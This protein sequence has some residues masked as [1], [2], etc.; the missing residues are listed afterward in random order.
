[1]KITMEMSKGAYEIAKKVYSE[2]L[3]R[4]EGKSEK[5]T[6][7]RPPFHSNHFLEVPL[8]TI[9]FLPAAIHF[10]KRILVCIFYHIGF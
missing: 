7:K 2:Q 1:M 3:I 4:I 8:A 6:K 5:A 9:K 10:M